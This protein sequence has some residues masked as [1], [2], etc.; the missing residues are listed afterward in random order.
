MPSQEASITL[1]PQQAALGVTLTVQLPT[2]TTQLRIPPCRDGDLVRAR[3][4]AGEVLLRVRV[5]AA[6]GA[7]QPAPKSGALGCLVFLAVVV[8]VI[9]GFS[10]LSDGDDSDGKSS[11]SPST[12]AW[13]T[14][15]DD[16]ATDPTTD[17]TSDP[18]TDP[19]TSSPSPEPT[20]FEQ[21]T[22][23]NGTLPDSTTPQ[24]VSGVEEVSCSASDAH[25]RVIESIPFT[26]DMNRCNGN[27]KTQYAFS[28]RYTLNG[29]VLNEYVYC[30]VGLGSYAR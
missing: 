16:M 28:Y 7:P 17:P 29:A 30:L 22:C 8:A 25:Y 2:G 12:S 27:P 13:T 26:S 15:P 3:V 1:T 20:P 18:T 10:V 4:G 24:S 6:A 5:S 11:A 9:V 19:T 23:L 14:A 21:G